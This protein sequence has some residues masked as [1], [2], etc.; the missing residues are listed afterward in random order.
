MT[1]LKPILEEQLRERIIASYERRVVYQREELEA[2]LYPDPRVFE[3][4]P[5]LSQKLEV[6]LR[7]YAFFTEM[8]TLL[9]LYVD[10]FGEVPATTEVTEFYK[11]FK[12]Q[13]D[14][15]KTVILLSK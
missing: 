5:D 9:S 15:A 13:L 10:Y 14:E 11:G 12:T 3:S 1:E 6:L 7:G 2:L 8:K 4:S